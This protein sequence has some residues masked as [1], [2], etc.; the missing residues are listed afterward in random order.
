VEGEGYTASCKKYSKDVLP[1]TQ[2]ADSASVFLTKTEGQLEPITTIS[3]SF[4]EARM[5]FGHHELTPL[6]QPIA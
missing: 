3:R 2:G 1:A 5:S 6:T 4:S